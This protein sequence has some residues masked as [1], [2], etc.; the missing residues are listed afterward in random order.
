MANR[1]FDAEDGAAVLQ[2]VGCALESC[3]HQLI[4]PAARIEGLAKAPNA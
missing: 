2:L 1:I 3:G 4:I